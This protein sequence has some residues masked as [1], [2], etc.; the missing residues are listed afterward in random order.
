MRNAVN[1]GGLGILTLM[2]IFRI[3]PN[4]KSVVYCTAIRIG[5]QPEWDFAWERYQRTNVGT[6]KDLLLHALGCS[7]ET[8]I[9]SRYLNWGF[10]EGSGIRKQDASRV[11]GSV[12]NNVIGQPLAFNYLRNQ[13]ARIKA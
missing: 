13:W 1:S 3:S 9:L 11:F 12:A 6:E 2:N 8:W 5:G 10:T 7:R 4:L